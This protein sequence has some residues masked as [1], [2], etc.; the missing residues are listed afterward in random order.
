MFHPSWNM[1]VECH[2]MVSLLSCFHIV[3]V[4]DEKCEQGHGCRISVNI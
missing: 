4:G 1:G 2:V 3:G